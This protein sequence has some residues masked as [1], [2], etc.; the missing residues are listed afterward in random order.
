MDREDSF[1]GPADWMHS[2]AQML[3][4]LDVGTKELPQVDFSRI[5]SLFHRCLA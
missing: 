4:K 1:N 3:L 5:L 2:P